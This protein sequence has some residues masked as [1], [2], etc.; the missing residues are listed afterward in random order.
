MTQYNPLTVK[1]SNSQINKLKS[2]I[3]NSTEETF[4]I[5]GD[6]N[7]ENDF[8]HKLLLTSTQVS[9]LRKAFAN[10]CSANIKLWKTRLRKIEE[11]RWFLDRLSG[12]LL[13]TELPLTGN[14]LKPLAKSVFIPLGLTEAASA[15]NAA[16]H[17]KLLW[18]GFKTLIISNE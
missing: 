17:K 3:K 8:S 12:L 5:D 14:V 13:K 1:L 6:S 10:T 9:K 11:S 15:T 7:D 18:F 2:A 4:N 16:T